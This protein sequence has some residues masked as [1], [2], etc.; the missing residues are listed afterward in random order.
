MHL[1]YIYTFLLKNGPNSNKMGKGHNLPLP[2]RG[3]STGLGKLA[4]W[5]VPWPHEQGSHKPK[6]ADPWNFRITLQKF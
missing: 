2:K 1:H 3:T 4:I 6:V 5:A